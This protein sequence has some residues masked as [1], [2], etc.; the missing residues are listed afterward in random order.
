M[1]KRM[2]E[3]YYLNYIEK[4]SYKGD[5]QREQGMVKIKGRKHIQYYFDG[6]NQFWEVRERAK[7]GSHGD[8]MELKIC[9]R[10]VGILIWSLA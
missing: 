9:R 8:G 5:I 4:L 3:K 1:H 7:W 6:N 10:N 2:R